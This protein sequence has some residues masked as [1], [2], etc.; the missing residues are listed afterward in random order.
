MPPKVQPRFDPTVNLGHLLTFMGFILAGY[1]AFTAVKSELSNVGVRV[2]GME[3]QVD[4]ITEVLVITATAQAE[5]VE[6][7][8]RLDRLENNSKREDVSR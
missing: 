7:R 3:K 5:I 4:R 8:R 2:A 6:L 1:A